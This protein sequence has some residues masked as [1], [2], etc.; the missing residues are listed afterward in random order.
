VRQDKSQI[1]SSH[2]LNSLIFSPAV[3]FETIQSVQNTR[4]KNLVRLRESSHRRRQSRFLVEGAREFQRALTCAWPM[5]SLYFC[6]DLFKEET[7]FALVEAA[8]SAGLEVIRLSPEAFAKAAFRQGP[9]GILA[10]G[11]QRTRSL[12]ELDLSPQPF[13]VVLEGIEKPG[14]IGAIFR[15]ASAAGA[16]AVVITNAVTDPYNPNAIRASQ[17]AFFQ[18][19]FC[20]TGNEELLIFLEEKYIQPIPTSPDGK[21]ILWEADLRQPMAILLGSEDT[22]LSA[23]WL[24][25][26]PAWKLPMKGVTDSLNVASMA[27]VALFEAVRQRSHLQE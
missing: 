27:A 6:E 16:D 25:A 3:M 4:V 26:F 24:D 15:T 12:S 10:T 11:I 20:C 19:P 13:L 17:G 8:E 21:R 7:S 5:E 9:D 22:G 14:N 18:T 2:Y 1:F 23:D